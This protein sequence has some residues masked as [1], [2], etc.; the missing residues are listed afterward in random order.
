[1]LT[2]YALLY[3]GLIV[4]FVYT[5]KTARH[6]R[7]ILPAKP[8]GT[9]ESHTPGVVVRLRPLGRAMKAREAVRGDCGYVKA[10]RS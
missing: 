4:L 1:M 5:A 10:V 2:V 9:Y 6:Q 8:H 3:L 7:P